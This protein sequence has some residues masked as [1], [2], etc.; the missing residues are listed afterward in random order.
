V[1]HR[2]TRYCRRSG[3]CRVYILSPGQGWHRRANALRL[4]A[5]ACC[6]TG[7]LRLHVCHTSL[8][9]YLSRIV[10]S[11]M[12]PVP[13]V[14]VGRTRQ[15][16]VMYHVEAE[17]SRVS[18][19]LCYVFGAKV[20]FCT[21]VQR[22]REALVAFR[23]MCREHALESAICV[24]MRALPGAVV[25]QRQTVSIVHRT[26]VADTCQ[27]HYGQVV[28]GRHGTQ[29]RVPTLRQF[30]TDRNRIYQIKI[31][32][33]QLKS[34]TYQIKNKLTNEIKPNQIKSNAAGGADELSEF[35]TE[36]AD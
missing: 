26:G 1:F 34:M 35:Q 10:L 36:G 23:V 11:S 3:A 25:I 7:P 31:K 22:G 18:R 8:H 33:Y 19:V 14:P 6:T 27:T 20:A 12:R 28:R 2:A 24:T 30:A 16:R 13:P 17:V 21:V 5:A 32:S 9:R 29:L 4:Q 15:Q